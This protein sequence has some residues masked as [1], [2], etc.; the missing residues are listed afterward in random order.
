MT[1]VTV[2]RLGQVNLNGDDNAL[3]LKIFS[4][5][6]LNTFD[7]EC[8]FQDK[9]L[10][11]EIKNGKSAQFPATGTIK[12]NYHTPGTMLTGTPIAHNERVIVIDDLLVADTYIANIDEAKNHYDIRSEYTK[13]L[14]Q[15]LA[16]AF[17]KNVARVGILAARESATIIGGFGGSQINGGGDVRTNGDQIGKAMFAA[18]QVLDEH[19]VPSTERFAYMRPVTYYAAAATKDLIN[20]DWNGAGSLA[21]GSID[22]VAGIK[23]VKTNNLPNSDESGLNEIPSKYRGDYSRTAFSVQHRSSVGTARLLNLGMDSQYLATHQA[24]LLVAKYALGHGILR[25][26]CAVEVTNY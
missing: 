18:A 1:D 20:K 4:G 23:I 9:H 26:E 21:A 16:N 2:S 6:V 15:A 11:R 19:D 5:E 10:I 7:R 3:F 24:T 8:V 17:D 14:G 25:P 12:A 13:Q 22:T